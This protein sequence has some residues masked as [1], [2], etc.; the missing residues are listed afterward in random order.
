VS[1]AFEIAN[2]SDIGGCGVDHVA[3]AEGLGCETI[4]NRSACALRL[5]LI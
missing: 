2:A 1:L 4:K 5:F 3:V